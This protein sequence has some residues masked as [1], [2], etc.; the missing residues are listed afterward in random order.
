MW[1]T[2]SIKILFNQRKSCKNL[3]GIAVD[4][5]IIRFLEHSKGGQKIVN[6]REDRI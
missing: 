1:L 3:P 2:E 5:K 6:D 4:L